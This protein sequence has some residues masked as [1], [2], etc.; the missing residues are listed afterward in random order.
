MIVNVPR[1]RLPY[2]HVVLFLVDSDFQKFPLN[3]RYVLGLG[4]LER[5]SVLPVRDYWTFPFRSE[6]FCYLFFS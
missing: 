5:T 3:Y 6:V 2:F 4:R 1:R